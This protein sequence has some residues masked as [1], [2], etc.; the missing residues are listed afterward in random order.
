MMGT[1]GGFPPAAAA[2]IAGQLLNRHSPHEIAEA[3]EVLLDVLNLMGGDPEAESATWPN[4]PLAVGQ[5]DL[6][7]DSEAGGDERDAA[8]IE[9]ERMAPATRKRGNHAGSENE[10]DEDD[11]PK[12]DDN[13]DVEHDGCEQ[14]D[15]V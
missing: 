2:H 8:W 3:V 4:D 7:D 12:E 13:F 5:A 1:Q 6:P 10:D 15:G 9:W 11:D 14:D